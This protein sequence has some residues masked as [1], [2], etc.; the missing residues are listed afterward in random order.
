MI[1]APLPPNE[2]ERIQALREFGILDTLE[3]QAFDDIT[4]L[5]S[6]ICET[7]IAVISLVDSERQWFK[8]RQGL[9]A[10]ETPREQAFCAHAILRPDQVL[11]VNDAAADPRFEDNPLVTDDPGIR[12]YAGAPLVT[13]AGL[14]MGALCVIDRQPRELAADRLEALRALARQVIAQLELRRVVGQL[15]QSRRQLEEYQREL[16]DA[17][18]VL[19]AQSTTDA[20]T[21]VRNRRAF[22]EALQE[23]LARAERHATAVSL[24]MIDVDEFK[25]YNDEFGHVAG[26]EALQDVARILTAYTRP[27]DVVARYGGEEFA[28]ILPNARVEAALRTGERLRRAVAAAGWSQRALTI[29]VGAGT[30]EGA[31]PASALIA[32]ADG[33][34]YRAK[35]EGR[36]LV[37]HASRPGGST[38]S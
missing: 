15:A 34:L 16:E 10:R 23:E 26:D 9:A 38:T 13:A 27:F 37:R 4:R 21:G 25:A 14:A 11:V 5:A 36:N 2:A 30:V 6:F 33:A 20:L 3:E 12:F 8:A 19:Q 29:S 22:D 18:L 1:A 31:A 32:A 17:N 24:L 28:V 35:R 7:P